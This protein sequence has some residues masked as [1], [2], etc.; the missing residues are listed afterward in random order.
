MQIDLLLPYV[1]NDHIYLFTENKQLE[2]R[3]DVHAQMET[4]SWFGEQST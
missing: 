1:L 3:E 2:V 4:Y